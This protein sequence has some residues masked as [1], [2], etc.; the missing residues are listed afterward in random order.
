MTEVSPRFS[1]AEMER[2]RRLVRA[3]MDERGLDALVVFGSSGMN[4]HDNVNAF[5]LS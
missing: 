3:L 2:R 5:W 1:A 4:Q